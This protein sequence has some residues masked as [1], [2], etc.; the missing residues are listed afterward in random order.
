VMFQPAPAPVELVERVHPGRYLDAIEALSDAGGGHVDADTA[1]SRDSFDVALRAAG[2]GLD[3]VARLEAGEADVAFCAVRPPGHHATPGRP[4]GFCLMNNVAVTAMALADR[5][6]RVLVVDYD[7]HHGNGTQDVF[8]ADPRVLYVSLHQHPLYPGTG[9]LGDIGHGEG[10]GTTVNLPLPPGAT[11][12]V[13]RAALDEVLV[14]LA[15]AWAPTW[16]LVSAGFDAHRL[17]PLTSLGLTSGDFAD[18]TVALRQLVGQGRCVLFLEGGYDLDALTACTG[19]VL[20]ALAGGN[21]RPEEASSGGPGL[22]VVAA[23]VRARA[24][25][26]T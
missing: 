2:A 17:D 26:G 15:E 8:Y 7:A 12:D 3:A 1:L 20:G 4:M 13:Y 16:L 9:A 18:I 14:P 19:A 25:Q 6:E 21:F 23:V 11:G 10:I 22:D 5:G 24:S